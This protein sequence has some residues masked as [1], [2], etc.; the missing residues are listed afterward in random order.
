MLT[1]LAYLVTTAWE[2]CGRLARDASRGG[3]QHDTKGATTAR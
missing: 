2:K 3:V 1:S